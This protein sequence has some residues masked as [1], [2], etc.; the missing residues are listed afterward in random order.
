MDAPTSEL[1]D[2]C[3]K[4]NDIQAFVVKYHPDMAPTSRH[5]DIFDNVMWHFRKVLDNRKKQ[6]SL[7]KYFKR[8]EHPV[9]ESS[10]SKKFAKE[11]TSKDD[12][13]SVFMERDSPS[14]Q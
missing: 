10:S 3:T 7:D 6:V 1:K 4:W 11:K 13:P 14:K 12:L 5:V 2:M 9:E 8:K